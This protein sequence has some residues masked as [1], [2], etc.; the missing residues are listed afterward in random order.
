M[1]FFE[2]F[3]RDFATLGIGK[4]KSDFKFGLAVLELGYMQILVNLPVLLLPKIT[5]WHIFC[6][7]P[8]SVQS[9]GISGYFFCSRIP[10]IPENTLNNNNFK[11]NHLII[12]KVTHYHLLY[13]PLSSL[14]DVIAMCPLYI[15]YCN[16][17][18]K[19]KKILRLY[20]F[21]SQYFCFVIPAHYA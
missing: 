17:G 14:I 6:W 10:E 16:N 15:F 1:Q 21:L 5:N 12:L 8:C 11:N 2:N 3:D 7:S 19:L 18:I 9:S 20:M 4:A 13:I